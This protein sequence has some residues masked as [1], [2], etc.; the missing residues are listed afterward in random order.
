MNLE[1]SWPGWERTDMKCRRES[2][3]LFCL[4]HK[5]TGRFAFYEEH[6]CCP[7]KD[8]TEGG[9]MGWRHRSWLE[10]DFSNPGF[11]SLDSSRP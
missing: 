4:P 2:Q 7:V 10:G 11:E 6:L 1:E 3:A 9:G 5:A 8:D